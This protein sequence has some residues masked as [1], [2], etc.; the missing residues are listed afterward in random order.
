MEVSPPYFG[1]K[2]QSGLV[3]GFFSIFP[4]FTDRPVSALF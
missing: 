4:D 3:S 1:E 2:S